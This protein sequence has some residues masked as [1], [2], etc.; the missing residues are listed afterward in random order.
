MQ[1]LP[2]DLKNV[3][4]T[5]LERFTRYELEEQ[6]KTLEMLLHKCLLLSEQERS[7][8][9]RLSSQDPQ[10]SIENRTCEGGSDN[11]PELFTHSKRRRQ[12]LR[13]QIKKI[14]DR[15]EILDSIGHDRVAAEST[16]N[17]K[18]KDGWGFW[19]T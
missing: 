12:T 18:V 4:F 7:R 14:Q 19:R 9:C 6:K 17:P 15:L 13:K 1:P 2:R 11:S 16:V 3:Y 5:V 10:N 8:P